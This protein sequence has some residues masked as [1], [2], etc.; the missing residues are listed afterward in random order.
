MVVTMVPPCVYVI[1]YFIKQKQ[2]QEPLAYYKGIPMLV[3][4]KKN[5]C[6]SL[7]G[8]RQPSFFIA[9]LIN[10]NGIKNL[11]VKLGSIV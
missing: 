2:A 1:S 8:L 6:Y 10:I 5:G 11:W 4:S 7:Q 9:F 3:I